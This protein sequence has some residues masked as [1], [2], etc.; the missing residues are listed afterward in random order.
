MKKE[1]VYIVVF[2]KHNLKRGTK[3]QWEV[4]ETVEFVNQ[5]RTRHYTTSSAIGDYLNRTMIT[6]KRFNMDNFSKFEKYI[7]TKYE[8]EITELDN[9]YSEQ[10]VPEVVVPVVNEIED[11]FGNFRDRNVF[12]KPA[13]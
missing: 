4:A 11:E 12:D 1:K 8:K 6:G 2:H 10:R 13:A 7:R 9:A 5:L 3:D